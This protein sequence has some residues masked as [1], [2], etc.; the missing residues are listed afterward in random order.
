MGT[1]RTARLP[2]AAEALADQ[3]AATHPLDRVVYRGGARVPV[4]AWAEAAALA[5]IA[6]VYNTGTLTV[7]CEHFVQLVELF[8]GLDCGW[9]SHPG[10]DKATRSLRT[11]EGAADRLISHHRCRWGFGLRPEAIT[12]VGGDVAGCW[13]GD[14]GPV[15]GP[16]YP[17]G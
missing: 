17:S 1:T 12:T 16:S 7:A 14:S 4:R 15:S 13:L 9:T 10:P 8:D 11:I 5:R 6:V 2:R 3:L